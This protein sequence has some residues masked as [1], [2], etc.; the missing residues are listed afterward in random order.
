[1]LRNVKNAKQVAGPSP[2]AQQAA[3][4]QANGNGHYRPAA[5]GNGTAAS[6]GHDHHDKDKQIFVSALLKEFIRAGK[7]E[8]DERSLANATNMLKRLYVYAFEGNSG[9]FS[10]GAANGAGGQQHAQQ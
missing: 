10:N 1:M 6:G 7:V 9:T 5:T 2:H 8:L 3:V 4:E